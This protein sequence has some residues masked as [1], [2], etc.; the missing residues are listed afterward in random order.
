VPR[1]KRTADGMDWACSFHRCDFG[2][3]HLLEWMLRQYSQQY[4]PRDL[5]D[6]LT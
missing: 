6:T 4:R 1:P 5:C 3:H 2:C